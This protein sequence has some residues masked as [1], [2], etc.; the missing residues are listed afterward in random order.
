M[1]GGTTDEHAAWRVEAREADQ[2]LLCDFLSY[3]R[4][5]LMAERTGPSATTLWFSTAIVARRTRADG[6][7]RLTRRFQALLPFHRRYAPILLAG[8]ARHLERAA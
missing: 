6:T 5:W 3:T 2:V 4:C 8:A 1:S 7:P